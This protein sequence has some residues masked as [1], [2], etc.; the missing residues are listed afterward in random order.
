MGDKG[1]KKCFYAALSIAT[2]RCGGRPW[3]TLVWGVKA[4][5]DRVAAMKE[6]ERPK[7]GRKS[8]RDGTTDDLVASDDRARVEL[9]EALARVGPNDK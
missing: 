8:R 9:A 4:H 2:A 7:V 6:L 5:D 1:V 3:V